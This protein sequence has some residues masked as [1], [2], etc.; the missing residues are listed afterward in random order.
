M[1][2]TCLK[3]V[4]NLLV[5]IGRALLFITFWAVWGVRNV[6]VGLEWVLKQSCVRAQI[7][8]IAVPEENQNEYEPKFSEDD[9]NIMTQK[10]RSENLTI[11]QIQERFN[12]SYRQAKKVKDR[13]NILQNAPD[14]HR[15]ANA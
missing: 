13:L 9:L 7:F 5:I 14:I 12:I 8:D 2:K 1:F 6:L 11:I 3:I 4:Q 15:I 10:V